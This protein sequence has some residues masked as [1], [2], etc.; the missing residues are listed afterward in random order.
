M[1]RRFTVLLPAVVMCVAAMAAP[2]SAQIR[3]ARPVAQIA[4]APRAELRGIV[5]DEQGRPLAGAVATALGSTTTYAVSDA[6]GRFLFHTLP[7]GPYLLRV[8][9]RG[10][11]P[12]PSRLIQINRDLPPVASIV[13]TRRDGAEEPVPVLAAGLG[14]A[15]ATAGTDAEGEPHDHGEVAWR[16]RHLKRSVLKDAAT[17]VIDV[18]GASGSL[19]DGSLDSLGWAVGSPARLAT[20]LFAEVPWNGHFDLL[21][22]TSFDR[23][24]DLFSLERMPHGIA[25]LALEAPTAGGQWSMRGAM[26]QGDL[27]SWVVAGS[28]RRAPATHRYE[29]G[30]SY[31]MQSYLG[32]NAT[33]LAAVAEGDRNAGVLY[34]YDEWTIS[35]RVM[36]TYGAKYARYDYLAPQGL[37]SPRASVTLTPIVN[38]TFRIR[39]AVSRRDSAPGAGEFVP[40]STGLW[41]PPERT[42]S[43]LTATRGFV[44][45]QLQH[46][47]VAAEREWAGGV[48]TGVR[49]FRQTVDNQIVTLFGVVMPAGASANLG[50]YFVASAGDIDAAGWGMSVSRTMPANVRASV[51]YT[52]ARSTW[53]GGSPDAA[54]LRLVALPVLRDRTERIHDLTTTIESTLPVTE[55]RVFAIYKINSGFA[56]A[57]TGAPGAGTRFDVQVNQSLPFLNFS[58]AQ[59][60]MLVAVRS[61][62]HD[63][64]LDTSVYDEL[65]VLRSPKRVVGGVTVRF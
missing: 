37:L 48:V 38:D 56:D 33:A 50:H 64:M 21:T 27:S 40:P 11:A 17:S 19:L 47:E 25:Y 62:F 18:A 55:T 20:S 34:G 30:L 1:T 44:P 60:E 26:T 12:A 45:Q 61:L 39:A 2:A 57:D 22:S 8:H 14:P 35:P 10:Y 59:W 9:L 15:D 24:Q 31:G 4:A 5:L 32:G 54:A 49:A 13:L 65:L 36:V 28:Y 23:P 46:A 52:N 7:Y 16:L 29:A 63:E 53:M 6:D 58:G 51:D 41:L 42:F 43:P 3:S